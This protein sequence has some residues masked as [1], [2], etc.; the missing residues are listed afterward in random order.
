MRRQYHRNRTRYDKVEEVMDGEGNRLQFRFI[1]FRKHRPNKPYNYGYLHV[2]VAEN[3]LFEIE[4]AIAEIRKRN[5][6]LSVSAI[7]TEAVKRLASN[8][9]KLVNQLTSK[10]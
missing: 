3:D 4:E 1:K 8:P 5:P 7:V 10:S 9:V 6:T 2:H